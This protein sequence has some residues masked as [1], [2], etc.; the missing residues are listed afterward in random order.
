MYTCDRCGKEKDNIRVVPSVNQLIFGGFPV[1]LSYRCA[2]CEV[3]V[4]KNM[5]AMIEGFTSKQRA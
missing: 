3:E 5:L 1:F 2:E 4:S